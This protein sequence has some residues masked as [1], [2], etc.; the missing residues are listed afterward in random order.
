MPRAQNRAGK[1]SI[2]LLLLFI[3]GYLP[4]S[5][6]PDPTIL[7]AYTDLVELCY[8]KLPLLLSL[9]EFHPTKTAAIKSIGQNEQNA[10]SQNVCIYTRTVQ[11][12]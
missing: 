9:W 6:P 10:L 3:Y 8:K 5:P 1:G 12:T 11:C 2:L 7:Y 4:P